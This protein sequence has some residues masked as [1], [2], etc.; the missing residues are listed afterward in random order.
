MRNLGRRVP[1]VE[2]TAPVTGVRGAF[3]IR[4]EPSSPDGS[5]PTA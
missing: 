3:A 1:T 2:I 5:C 4:T